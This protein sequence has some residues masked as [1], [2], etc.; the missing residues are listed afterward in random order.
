MKTLPFPEP[1]QHTH[2]PI[3]NVNELLKAQTT[4]GQRAADRV[5][6]VVGSW[7]FIIVQTIL[8]MIWVTLN[9]LALTLRWDPYPFI[10]LNLFLSTEAAFTA[11]I[12]MMSQ[13]RQANKDRL[14]AHVDYAVNQKSEVE[15]RAI[16]D[17][18]AAQN[19]AL[20]EMHRLLV[21]LQSPSS[22]EGSD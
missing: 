12:I 19:V 11:P 5:A 22:Q 18:L 13:N 7:Q 16:L 4:R 8:L 2:P 17:V 15:V 6:S 10:L 1:Y 14:E 20:N 9:T 3:Q 21:Q